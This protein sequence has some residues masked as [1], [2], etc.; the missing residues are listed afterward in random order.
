MDKLSILFLGAVLG[1]IITYHW[2]RRKQSH[3]TIIH[4]LNQ[5]IMT[6]QEAIQKLDTLATQ[7]EKVK[8]EVQALVDAAGQEDEVSPEL[9]AAIDRV[10][11]AVQGVDDLNPDATEEPPV[12]E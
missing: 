7:V 8:T 10:S 3:Y 1:G 9:Q 11:A 2:P 12:T 6:Q 4:K 5:L